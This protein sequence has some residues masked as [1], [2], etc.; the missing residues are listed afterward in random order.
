MYV[1][2]H[3]PVNNRDNL[4][5]LCWQAA[6]DTGGVSRTRQ[7]RLESTPG[8]PVRIPAGSMMRMESLFYLEKIKRIEVMV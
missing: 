2:K 8:A 1:G 5:Q 3:Q 7:R 4:N 6:E